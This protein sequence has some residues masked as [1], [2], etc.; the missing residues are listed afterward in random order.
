MRITSQ[1]YAY[2]NGYF[3]PGPAVAGVTLAMAPQESQDAI[4][5]FGRPEYDQWIANNPLEVPLNSQQ[6]VTAFSLWDQRIGAG[7]G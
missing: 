2:D 1:A 3:Y 4:K 6:M 5:S 7:K